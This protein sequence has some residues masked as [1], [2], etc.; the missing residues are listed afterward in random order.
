[1]AAAGAMLSADLSAAT[2]CCCRYRR[3]RAPPRL[4]RPSHSASV[5]RPRRL[6][7]SHRRRSERRGGF[8][9]RRLFVRVQEFATVPLE[10]KPSRRH[11]LGM[12]AGVAGLGLHATAAMAAQEKTMAARHGLIDVHHHILPP[13]A[14]P[15]MRALF[16]G[17]TP[18]SDLAAMDAAGVSTAIVLPGLMVGPDPDQNRKLSRAWN[19]YG[20][21][22][23]RDHPGRFG[24]FAALPMKDVEG[25]LAEIDHA[26]RPV[27]RRRLWRGD[28]LRR[29]L[30]GRRRLPADLG[31][32]EQPARCGLR[33]SHRCAL[34]RA[35]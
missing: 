12:A 29:P 11:L 3:S 28:Q 2:S 25:S 34:L 15:P 22:L 32:A 33:S 23:G 8:N 19:E 16:A 4:L 26:Y 20:A 21:G 27:A 18:Q 10:I 13:G 14:P 6:G 7:S 1:M 9:P 17:W 5:V 24:L 30:A 31:Q 35:R